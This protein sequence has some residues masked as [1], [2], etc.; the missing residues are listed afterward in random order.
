MWDPDFDIPTYGETTFL[1]SEDKDRLM[2]RDE[3][4]L[5]RDTMKQFRQAFAMGCLV[6]ANKRDRRAAEEQRIQENVE[7]RKEIKHLQSELIHSNGLHQKVGRLRAKKTKEA[8]HRA[9]EA[10]S[11]AEERNKLLA[12]VDKLKG[13]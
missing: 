12:E 5:L 2:A 13:N 6:V 3:D 9:Q 11:L 4:H 10:A 8:A 7:L 1:P